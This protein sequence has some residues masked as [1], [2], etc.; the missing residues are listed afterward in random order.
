MLACG[1][2]VG[3]FGDGLLWRGQTTD[4]RRQIIRSESESDTIR[5]SE[6]SEYPDV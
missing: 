4:D 3:S 6:I 5:D 2:M 1:G